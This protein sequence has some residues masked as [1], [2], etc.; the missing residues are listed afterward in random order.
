MLTADQ[1]T[2]MRSTVE[3]TFTDSCVIRAPGSSVF[4]PTDGSYD[5]DP[6]SSSYSGVCKIDPTG[7]ER[8]LVSAG[9]EVTVRTY[10]LRLP[11]SATGPEVGHVATIT[12]ADGRLNGQVMRVLDVQGRTIPLERVLIVEDDLG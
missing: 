8:V 3:D 4:D 12:S 2:S 6:G 11:H 5:T 7:G 10:V 1:L 9:D